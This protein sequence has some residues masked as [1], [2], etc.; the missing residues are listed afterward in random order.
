[1]NSID[2]SEGGPHFGKG[3]PMT[4]Y[5]TVILGAAGMIVLFILQIVRDNHKRKKMLLKKIQRTYGNVPDR[6]YEAGDI[7]KLSGFFLRKQGSGF[8]IDD[9]TWNDLDMDRIYM[10]VNQTMSSP[11]E[12][13]LYAMLRMPLFSEEE[14]SRREKLICYFAEHPKEREKMQF[15]LSEVGKT[16]FGSLSETILAL[17]HAPKVS[18]GIHWVMLVVLVLC[19]AVVLPLFPLQ[20]FF[21]LILLC[22][23]NIT[24]YYAG[25]DRELIDAYLDCFSSLLRMLG[26]ADRMETVDWPEV[27]EQMEHIRQG[28]KTFGK[29]RRRAFILTSKDSTGDPLQILMDYIRM[30]LHVDILIYNRILKEVQNKTDTIM[31]LVE[32]IGEL[33]AAISIASFREVLPLKCRPEFVHYGGGA[34]HAEVTDLYHPLIRE[35]VANSIRLEGGTLITG[36]NASGKSTFLKNIAINAILAQTL[37]TCTCASYR[38]PFLKVMTSM[39]LR[40]D[41][42]GGE[43]YFIVE[44]KSL[45]RI[46]DESRKQEPLLCIIDEVLRGTNTIERIAA[47]SR[48]LAEL[49][50]DWVLP[51]AATHDIEL[52]YILERLY[53]NYHFEEEVR[54]HQV[55]FNYILQ[56]GRATTRNAIRLLDMLGYDE[57]IVEQA[58]AAAENFE[59][60][61]VWKTAEGYSLSSSLTKAGNR[62]HER[63]EG[64]CW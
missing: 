51:V 37:V 62:K 20:G 34:V 36:S 24:I 19:A 49:A 22:I 13:V 6:S 10:L 1:M 56:N 29:L 8:V 15:L 40:D 48:I 64:K 21:L 60:T 5:L 43:S 31:S 28:K 57:N 52:S 18:A 46:L 63:E 45:K 27:Q 12:E 3:V 2:F 42:Q 35:A 50:K 59:R 16:R 32:N 41:L 30:V 54:E 39:A 38:A 4:P 47:S 55:I 26:C 11:G 61:G 25:K 33:D 53:Q 7:Q 17:E 23:L 44:I 58:R 14:I 9:I